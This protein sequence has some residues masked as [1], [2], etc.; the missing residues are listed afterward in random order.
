MKQI[1]E[2]SFQMIAD[3][4]SANAL[5]LEAVTE[6]KK[7]KIEGARELLR[8]GERC[9]RHSHKVHAELIMKMAGGEEIP[10]DMILM[11]AEDQLMNAEVIKL[12]AEQVIDLCQMVNPLKE[13]IARLEERWEKNR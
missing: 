8:K 5:Y 13:R 2:I 9:Y 7:G 1:E 4:G 3:V 6:A 12:M 11:H 10:V